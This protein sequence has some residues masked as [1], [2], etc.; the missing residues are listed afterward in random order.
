MQEKNS[1]LGGKIWHGG[2]AY[3]GVSNLPNSISES[4]KIKPVYTKQDLHDLKKVAFLKTISNIGNSDLVS[5]LGS[6]KAW[7]GATIA[8]SLSGKFKESRDNNFLQYKAMRQAQNRQ[9]SIQ[10]MHKVAS[11]IPNVWK[12]Y[13]NDARNSILSSQYE[14]FNQM[15][16]QG[17]FD[18]SLKEAS[19]LTPVING[20]SRALT[21]VK[22]T[23]AS[24][25]SKVKS[26]TDNLG[27]KAFD[28]K[29]KIRSKVGPDAKTGY[30][31]DNPLKK[32]DIPKPYYDK[33]IYTTPKKEDSFIRAAKGIAGL[34]FAAD[35]LIEANNTRKNFQYAAPKVKMPPIKYQQ[36]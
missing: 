26:F 13:I 35:T 21:P 17:V 10:Q 2:M 20:A 8:S 12:Y 32:G 24:G 5:R 30:Y 16:K 31:R 23:I 18:Y 15:Q 9:N 6:L 19:V 27:E 11:A 14:T 29:K 22:N 34:T 28:I 3:L 36:Q 25:I 7:G 33:K 4:N 1:G